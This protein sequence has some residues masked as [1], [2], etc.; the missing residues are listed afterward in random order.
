[1][2]KGFGSEFLK[3]EAISEKLQG[4]SILSSLRQHAE[5][6]QSCPLDLE[7]SNHVL[8]FYNDTR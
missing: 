8:Y 2:S 5:D 1:M 6:L 3:A 4:C 7:G